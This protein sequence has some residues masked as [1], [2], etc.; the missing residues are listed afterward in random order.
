[1]MSAQDELHKYW[2]RKG[3]LFAQALLNCASA[4]F[5]SSE[6]AQALDDLAA[7]IQKTLTLSNLIGR[8]RVLMEASY[9]NKK[10][11]SHRFTDIPESAN[12]MGTLPFTEAVEEVLDREPTI[13]ESASPMDFDRWR[14]NAAR[15]VQELYSSR[16]AFAM[17]RSADQKLTERIQKEIPKLLTGGMSSAQV[18]NEILNIGE[19]AAFGQVRDWNRAYAATVYRNAAATAYNGGRFEQAADPEIQEV[20]PALI[21]AGIHDGR[22]RRNHQAANGTIADVHHPIWKRIK[23][24]MGHQCRDS[25]D[26]IG[27]FELE[28]MGL[29]KEGKVIPFFP[30]TIGEAGPDEGFSISAIEF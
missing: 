20:V 5:Q 4:R 12:P 2:E 29:F 26:L 15:E 18:E 14:A 17:A 6:R 21:H 22:Q 25:A 30:P 13:V 27:R 3:Q 8:K 28:R 24:P 11:R 7:L 16:K 1:M 23:P 19:S 9:I 10:G